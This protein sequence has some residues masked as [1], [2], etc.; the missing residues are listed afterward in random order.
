[1][2]QPAADQPRPAPP[3]PTPAAPVPVSDR[4]LAAE[5]AA[6]RWV[7]GTDVGTYAYCGHLFWH[8]RVVRQGLDDRAEVSARLS[9]GREQHARHSHAAVEQQHARHGVTQAIAWSASG[10]L[11]M[12]ALVMLGQL[13]SGSATVDVGLGGLGLGAGVALAY[14]WR[15]RQLSRQTGLPAESRIEAVDDRGLPVGP[16]GGSVSD[17]GSG[18]ASVG[19][20]D[21]GAP[22]RAGAGERGDPL[23]VWRHA[24]SGL[25]GTPDYVLAEDTLD[26]PRRVPV[27]IKPTRTVSRLYASDELQLVHYLVLQRLLDAEHAAGYGRVTYAQAAF[28]IELTAERARWHA[29]VVERVRA[30]RQPGAA[31]VPRTHQVAGRCRGC[32]V[33]AQCTYSLWTPEASAGRPRNGRPGGGR[34]GRRLPIQGAG[35]AGPVPARSSDAGPTSGQP[36]ATAPSVTPGAA[37]FPGGPPLAG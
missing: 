24:G 10:G 6:R 5:A 21:R 36:P 37:G 4:R 1:M 23:P 11:V 34:P 8:T 33:R 35:P 14:I 16:T 26:G 7:S 9:V 3:G 30:A 13:G 27:E 18:E 2:P 20:D 22:G 17:G 15:T 12:W 31:P 28:L 25:Y 32:A 29:D 19:R